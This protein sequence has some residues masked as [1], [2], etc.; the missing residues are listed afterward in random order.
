MNRTE[1]MMQGCNGVVS[2]SVSALLR[3]LKRLFCIQSEW[4]VVVDR[5]RNLCNNIGT[6]LHYKCWTLAYHL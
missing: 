1:Q 5:R 2:V 4:A 6:N 3:F